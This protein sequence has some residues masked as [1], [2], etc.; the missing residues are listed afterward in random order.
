MSLIPASVCWYL[1]SAG[2]FDAAYVDS[3]CMSDCMSDCMVVDVDSDDSDSVDLI[4]AMPAER[5]C[6]WADDSV[7][8]DCSE[9][10]SDAEGMGWASM[11]AGTGVCRYGS[12]F[13]FVFVSG[14][15]WMVDGFDGCL[16][17]II[18]EWSGAGRWASVSDMVIVVIMVVVSSV[19][20]GGAEAYVEDAY[21]D[22]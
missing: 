3:H 18:C 14:Y 4:V 9:T 8:G 19:C 20:V 7:G 1:L 21:A 16:G 13:L 17:A 15:L 2:G 10:I 6:G 11:A 5:G 22:L 12:I